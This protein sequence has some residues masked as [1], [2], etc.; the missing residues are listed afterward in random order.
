MDNNCDCIDFHFYW[1]DTSYCLSV[2]DIKNYQIRIMSLEC[3]KVRCI[4]WYQTTIRLIFGSY[5][6]L[7]PW[8]DCYSR[9]YLKLILN[10]L[11]LKSGWFSTILLFMVLNIYL[12]ISYLIQCSNFDCYNKH[13]CIFFIWIFW[14]FWKILLS[15]WIDYFN[16]QKNYYFAV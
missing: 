14:N 1:S 4:Y 9:E 10:I 8:S 2:K 5:E 12:N 16:F 7:L 15:K 6:L 3:F 11:W 13:S